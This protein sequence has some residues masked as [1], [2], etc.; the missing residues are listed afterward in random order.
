MRDR[1]QIPI[2]I[3]TNNQP[4]MSVSKR[5]V[6][7][8][9]LLSI[10]STSALAKLGFIAP[11]SLSLL[12][13]VASLKTEPAHAHFS[14][15]CPS[16]PDQIVSEKPLSPKIETSKPSQNNVWSNTDQDQ[17]DRFNS[18]NLSEKPQEDWAVK[19]SC[20]R[21]RARFQANP[22]NEFYSVTSG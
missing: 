21:M 10:A 5:S 17:L 20:T 11:I 6:G 12:L 15:L 9:Y 14:G 16:L 18:T 2:V 8:S 13:G 19:D 3:D 4:S 1:N 22:K 7:L